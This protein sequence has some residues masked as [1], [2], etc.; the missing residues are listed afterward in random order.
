MTRK[1]FFALILMSLQTVLA[2]AQ[3]P[4][5]N[6]AFIPGEKLT[7]DL[8][9]NWKFI[10]VKAGSAHYSIKSVEYDGQESLRSDLIFLSNKR[11]SAIFPMKDTLVSITSPDLVPKYFRKGSAEGSRYTVNE[12]WYDF[13]DGK[14]VLK[15]KYLNRHG[16]WSEKSYESQE[17]NFDMLSILSV[18][19]TFDTSQ[20]ED[21]HRIYFPMASG[22]KVEMQ[23]LVFRGREKF[24]ANDGVTYRCLVFSLLDQESKKKEKELL[25][26]YITDDLNHL[27]V[28]IDFYLKFGS[29]KAFYVKGENLRNPQTSIVKKKR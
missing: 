1:H 4:Y 3:C 8:Y 18:A 6:N 9:F 7:Y 29:A 20:Y 28:R 21:G 12:V 15:Q 14:N 11:C 19:R 23:T 25:R 16:V 13:V 22:R 26:F 24:E 27:P 10:W 17:C 2:Y 5:E